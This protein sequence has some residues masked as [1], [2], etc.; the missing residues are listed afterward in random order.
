MPYS[1]DSPGAGAW[2]ASFFRVGLARVGGQIS[3][4]APPSEAATGSVGSKA[5]G[6]GYTEDIQRPAK[7]QRTGGHNNPTIENTLPNGEFEEGDGILDELTSLEST[8]ESSI[9]RIQDLSSRLR[10]AYPLPHPVTADFYLA[11]LPSLIDHRRRLVR[12]AREGHRQA[13]DHAQTARWSYQN[14]AVSTDTAWLLRETQKAEEDALAE[15]T[16]LS[17]KEREMSDKLATAQLAIKLERRRE[18]LLGA[19]HR[20][21]DVADQF[22]VRDLS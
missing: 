3:G 20:L 22:W 2:V 4:S 5:A 7:K 1:I 18:T 14:Q 12:L 19:I 11:S 15:V 9:A 21:L 8:V 13:I 10:Q 17:E 6:G 16:W